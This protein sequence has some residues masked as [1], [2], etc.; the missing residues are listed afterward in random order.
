M[1]LY[2]LQ[3]KER[4]C[5]GSCLMAYSFHEICKNIVA[6]MSGTHAERQSPDDQM[7]IV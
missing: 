3:F 1:Q 5:S 2:N 6:G 7:N 4:L